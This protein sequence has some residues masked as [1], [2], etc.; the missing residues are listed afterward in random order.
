MSI[1]AIALWLMLL[2][3]TALILYA[4]DAQKTKQIW[5]RGRRVRLKKHP[6]VFTLIFGFYCL[7]GLA[8]SVWTMMVMTVVLHPQ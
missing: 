5:I 2:T 8:L 3:S 6:V 1:S 7:S 4:L